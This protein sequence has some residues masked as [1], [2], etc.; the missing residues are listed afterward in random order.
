MGFLLV[1]VKMLFLK[2]NDISNYELPDEEKKIRSLAQCNG[3]AKE[4]K[5]YI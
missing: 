4:N 5:C 2:V 1:L 3:W